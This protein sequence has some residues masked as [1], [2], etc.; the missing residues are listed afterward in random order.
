MELGSMTDGQDKWHGTGSAGFWGD[1]DIW[2]LAIP[3]GVVVTPSVL[4]PGWRMWQC[5]AVPGAICE[6]P[7][8]ADQILVGGWE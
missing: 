1:R 7:V 5:L 8:V 4:K 6:D 2:E 3:G